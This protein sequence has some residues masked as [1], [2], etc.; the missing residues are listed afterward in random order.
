MLT[1]VAIYNDGSQ[2]PQYNEDKSENKYTDIKRYI[3]K[4]FLL[5]D[6]TDVR[7]VLNLRPTLKLIYRRRV[8][9]SMDNKIK[10]I[11]HIIG[12][13]QN[14]A[15]KNIQHLNFINDTTGFIEVTDGFQENHPWFYPVIFLPEEQ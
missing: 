12:Y 8:A 3:L 4:Q 14:I 6:G 5:W 9:M 10:N 11:I 7:F 1:W 2:L 15:G 13:Q